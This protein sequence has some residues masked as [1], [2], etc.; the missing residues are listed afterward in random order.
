ML[1]SAGASAQSIRTLVARGDLVRVRQ[2]VYIAASAWPDEV[3]DQ[4]LVRSHAELVIHPDAVISHESAAVYWRLPSPTPADWHQANPSVTLMS[5]AGAKSRPGPATHH[6]GALPIGQISRDEEGYAV[7]SPTRTGIDL[8]VGL[9]LPHALAV[10]DGAARRTIESMIHKPRR[11][12][13]LNP[14]YVAAARELLEAAAAARRPA[15]LHRA[16]ALVVPARES[17]AESL[18]AGHMVL[19]GLSLPEFQHTIHTPVGNMYPDFYWPELRLIGEVDGRVKYAD[20]AAYEREKMREQVLRDLGYRI[21]RWTAR[22]IM[23]TPH[24]VIERIA[25]ALGV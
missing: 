9:D 1:V 22:E 12:D 3:R 24:V 6:I 19:E 13:Y 16:I 5:T 21:V 4:H 2:G 17:V 10:L 20:P 14:R 11:T 7:T 18:A 23:F 25:R 15:G 8:A